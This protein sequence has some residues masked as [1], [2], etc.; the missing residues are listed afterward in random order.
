MGTCSMIWHAPHDKFFS[1][2]CDKPEHPVLQDMQSGSTGV[3]LTR[4]SVVFAART[5]QLRKG[6]EEVCV[7][8]GA[9][10][11][12]MADVLRQ[13]ASEAYLDDDFESAIAYFAQASLVTP[14]QGCQA[15]MCGVRFPRCRHMVP[16]LTNLDLLRT[17]CVIDSLPRA[18]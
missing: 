8:R 11:R 4:T 18:G 10:Q 12:S 5:D 2:L 9:W 7:N 16:D 14:S 13:K 1:F 17:T 3:R 15:S 6:S